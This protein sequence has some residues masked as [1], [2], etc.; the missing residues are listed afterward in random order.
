MPPKH[1][2]SRSEDRVEMIKDSANENGSY[3]SADPAYIERLQDDIKISVRRV[4]YIFICFM[5]TKNLN[6]MR[7]HDV[8]NF[9][10]NFFFLL[11][12]IASSIC[13][14]RYKASET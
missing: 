5:L 1:L 13:N 3:T 8:L 11:P 4:K 12:K 9:I 10:L 7:K 14:S 2:P 6:G